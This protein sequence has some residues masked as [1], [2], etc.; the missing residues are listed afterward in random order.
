[1]KKP[2]KL[3]TSLGEA[4]YHPVIT[5]CWRTLRR[6]EIRGQEN[7]LLN[8]YRSLPNPCIP[9]FYNQIPQGNRPKLVSCNI[10][11]T[12]ADKTPIKIQG[13]CTINPGFSHFQPQ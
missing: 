12:T 9:M 13:K 5:I 10:K 4:C 6:R 7:N 1:M 11:L 3:K 2:E 8:R